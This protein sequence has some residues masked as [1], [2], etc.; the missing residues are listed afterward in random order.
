MDAPSKFNPALTISI[1]KEDRQIF[2]AQVSF[3]GERARIGEIR[4]VK[5]LLSHP[6]RLSTQRTNAQQ[7]K[8]LSS[9]DH[10]KAV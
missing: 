3:L 1:Q 9:V 2:S 6:F 8:T 7:A 5:I 4:S 10:M